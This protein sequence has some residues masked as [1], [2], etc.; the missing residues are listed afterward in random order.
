LTPVLAGRAACLFLLAGTLFPCAE[1]RGDDERAGI[2]WLLEG[3]SGVLELRLVH[4]E[5]RWADGGVLRVDPNQRIV[6]WEGIPGERGCRQK[7]EV[8]FSSVRAVRD[9]AQGEIR[10][11]IK[12]QP[13][14]R[15]L[16]V[17]LPHAAWV[18]RLS[19]AVQSGIAPGLRPML[20][21]PD[22]GGSMPVGGFAAFAGPQVRRDVVPSEVTAD[23][24]L[25]VDRIRQALGRAPV[26]S[27]ELY[28]A[29]HG[30][31]VE[32]SIP[33][34]L[35]Q[36]GPLE[37]RAVRVRGVAERLPHGRGL[38]LAEEGRTVRIVP[39]PEIAAVVQSLVRDWLGQEVEVAGIL[40]RAAAP[41]ADAPAHEVGFWEYLGPE[42]GDPSADK[43]RAVTVREL[44]ER[45]SEFAGQTVRVVGRFRGANLEHDLPPPR[46]RSAWVIKSARYAI[47]VT[48]HGPSGRGFA[49]RSD[50]EADTHK[51]LEVVGRPEQRKG[52]TVLHASSVALSAPMAGLGLRRRLVTSKQ[53][54]VV[55]TLPLTG[56]EAVPPDARFLVQFSSYMDEESFEGRV[57]LRYGDASAGD[58]PRFR[59][60]YDDVRRTLVVEPG[61]RLRAGATLELLLLPGITDAFEVPLGAGPGAADAAPRVL[62]W[63]VEG[64]PGRF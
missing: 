41:A 9:E 18:A 57:R 46:P 30:R 35:A 63:Q 45:P 54:D 34:L 15:W 23:V 20:S 60:T 36:P 51:W 1:A 58:L 31:P 28:E 33:E 22:G 14:D 49:L 27:V 32:V 3:G 44:V 59:W 56:D 43:A 4:D 50:L 13:R 48:G 24:R 26:P 11:E 25:A 52:L 6:Q 38:A 42:A 29:L 12:G 10:L 7:L 40:K 2:E 64:E 5:Q 17:P 47:W 19:S 39:Q 37:G 55:F 16:F 53:P 21:G 61:E 62:R 8:P